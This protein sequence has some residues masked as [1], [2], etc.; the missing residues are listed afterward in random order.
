MFT[1]EEIAKAIGATLVANDP[2]V[3]IKTIA[4]LSSAQQ[5]DITFFNARALCIAIERNESFGSLSY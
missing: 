1:L 2:T 4:T 3:K 5:G